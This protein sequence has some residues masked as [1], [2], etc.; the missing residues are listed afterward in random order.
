MDTW[1]K[2]AETAAPGPNLL[3]WPWLAEHFDPAENFRGISIR[4]PKG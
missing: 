3:G 4:N 1:L 2:G